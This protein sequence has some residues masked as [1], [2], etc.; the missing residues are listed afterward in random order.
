[1][2]KKELNIRLMH[3]LTEEHWCK[4]TATDIEKRQRHIFLLDRDKVMV[5]WVKA[6]YERFNN[7]W[8]DYTESD[9]YKSKFRRLNESQIRNVGV[10]K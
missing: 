5:D 2:T 8:K 4:Y 3:R 6:G 7:V 1:M 9:L 10:K